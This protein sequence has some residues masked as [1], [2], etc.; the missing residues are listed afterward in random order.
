MV[1]RAAG[2]WRQA[3]NKG[4]LVLSSMVLALLIAELSLRLGVP[5]KK[6]FRP[7]PPS[8]SHVFH[9]R[10]EILVD[11]SAES[12]FTVNSQ[13]LRG[14]EM[15]SDGE[16]R[17][18]AIGG[19]TTECLFL[20]DSAAWPLL[21]SKRLA[22]FAN[23]RPVWSASSGLSGKKSGD[24][25]LHAK[26]L[27]PELPRIDIVVLLAGVNDLAVAL[28][29]P[30]SYL[31][32]P[33]DIQ[34]EGS[35]ALFF[36]AFHQVPGRLE[37]TADYEGAF[38][39]RLSVYQEARKL[40]RVWSKNPSDM[41]IGDDDKGL[42]FLAWRERRKRAASLID[43]LPDLTAATATYR[44][45]LETFVDLVRARSIRPLLVTQPALW[46]EGMSAE[47]EKLL[48]MGGKGDFLAQ[49]G[50]PYFTPRVLAQG[51]RRFNET[52]L[53]VCR[54]RKVECFDLASRIPSDTTFFYDDCHFG[55]H[56]SEKIADLLLEPLKSG[57][58]FTP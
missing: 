38:Y 20:D 40:K 19:S 52:M 57:P 9:H 26:F 56:G 32:V 45:N 13:G 55:N 33:P 24:H 5:Q 43:E 18:L 10:P 25:V 35:E 47:D 34:P 41:N 27:V 50:L 7:W 1:A 53:S 4:A 8:F 54:E 21:L 39:R 15:G 22:P 29:R 42:A 31:P 2:A 17:I 6:D 51:L 37:S 11:H 48:W 16:V 49:D 30:E 23:G 28:G 36:R 46:H 14:P 58:P 44:K 3:L 12:R